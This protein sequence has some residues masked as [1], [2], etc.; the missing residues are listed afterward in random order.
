MGSTTS[1]PISVVLADSVLPEAVTWIEAM[2]VVKRRKGDDDEG[3][4]LKGERKQM[5]T[6]IQS[7]VGAP[8]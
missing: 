1:R 2:V 8:S 7:L 5:V 3:Q 6:R 4:H